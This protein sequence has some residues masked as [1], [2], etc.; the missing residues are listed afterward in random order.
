M[1]ISVPIS[2]GELLDKITILQIK[3]ERIS[4]PDKNRNVVRELKELLSVKENNNLNSAKLEELLNELKQINLELWDIED[5]IRKLEY[6]NRF[7]SEFIK[8]AR[9]VYITND[10]RAEVKKQINLLTGSE[11]IEEKSYAKAG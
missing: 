5:D 1:I 3:Q 2:T 10:K 7:D 11:L 6:E 8:L 4:D 9:S